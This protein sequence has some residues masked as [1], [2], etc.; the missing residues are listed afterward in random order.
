M[1]YVKQ[2]YWCSGF[3]EVVAPEGKIDE[4]SVLGQ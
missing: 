1:L 3:F 2:Q 4:G